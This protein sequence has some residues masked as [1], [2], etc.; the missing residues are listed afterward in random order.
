[1]LMAALVFHEWHTTNLLWLPL[2]PAGTE[3]FRLKY[4]SVKYHFKS[5]AKS[6]FRHHYTVLYITASRINKSKTKYTAVCDKKTIQMY[7]KSSSQGMVSLV[8]HKLYL[9]SG[10]LNSFR[11]YC[12]Q[13]LFQLQIAKSAINVGIYTKGNLHIICTVQTG[14]GWGIHV[15]PASSFLVG[16]ICHRWVGCLNRFWGLRPGSG[17]AGW[18]GLQWEGNFQH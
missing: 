1:M 18:R 6:V 2:K 5:I 14:G 3:Q 9:T 16:N 10:I 11:R 15:R 7:V 8:L 4:T 12:F 17:V 13:D